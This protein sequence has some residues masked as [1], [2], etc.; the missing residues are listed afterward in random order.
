MT[1]L[2][3]NKSIYGRIVSSLITGFGSKLDYDPHGAG[4]CFEGW[5][6]NPVPKIT[7][8]I[9]IL[10]NTPLHLSLFITEQSSAKHPTTYQPTTRLWSSYNFSIVNPLENSAT[11]QT[12]WKLTLFLLLLSGVSRAVQLLSKLSHLFTKIIYHWSPVKLHTIFLFFANLQT[13]HLH[14][15]KSWSLIGNGVPL[16]FATLRHIRNVSTFIFSSVSDL[17]FASL[18]GIIRIFLL[19]LLLAPM[20]TIIINSA[21]SCQQTTRWCE[22]RNFFR[23]FSTKATVYDRFDAILLL[24][25]IE[26]SSLKFSDHFATTSG[27]QYVFSPTGV[28]FSDPQATLNFSMGRCDLSKNW[29]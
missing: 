11:K 21:L 3:Y 28:C 10:H 5:R 27:R 20:E 26:H 12:D 22:N 9:T 17:F 23:M 13:P 6:P 19:N 29:L 18:F 8:S 7:P 1:F 15:V 4:P 2:K 24:A 14:A 16:L 25:E